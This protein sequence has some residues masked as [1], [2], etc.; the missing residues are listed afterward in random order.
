M[1][2]RRRTGGAKQANEIYRSVRAICSRFVDQCSHVAWG[3]SS[4]GRALLLTAT[5]LFDGTLPLLCSI[6]LASAENAPP[7]LILNEDDLRAW[8]AIREAQ[9][10]ETKLKA[11][12]SQAPIAIDLSE[13]PGLWAAERP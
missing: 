1:V 6:R 7:R 3:P 10:A 12:R 8:T 13:C 2:Q 11:K 9:S 5:Q 4:F